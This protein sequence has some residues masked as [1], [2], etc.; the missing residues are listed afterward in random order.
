MTQWELNTKLDKIIE[1]NIKDIPWEG[2]GFDIES[3]KQDI[4]DFIKT[5]SYTDL[6]KIHEII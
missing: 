3:L 2:T 1:D 6:T 5:F 4:I